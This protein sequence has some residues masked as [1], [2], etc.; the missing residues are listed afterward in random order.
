[1]RKSTISDLALLPDI[2]TRRTVGQV[3]DDAPFAVLPASE[4]DVAQRMRGSRRAAARR[5]AIPSASHRRSGRPGRAGSRGPM[6]PSICVSK[7]CGLL[8]LKTTRVRL[9]ACTTFRLRS[10]GSL[11]S[12]AVRP[13]PLPVSGKSSAMR[14]GLL[15]AKP[16]GGLA[17]GCLHRELDDR[18]SRGAL[19]H[20]DRVDAVGR[21]APARGR[22]PRRQ[23]GERSAQPCAPMQAPA[24][25]FNGWQ[26]AHLRRSCRWSASASWIVLDRSVQSPAPSCTSS[27]SLNFA[28]GDLDDNAEVLPHVVANLDLI[29]VLVGR[30]YQGIG[31]L[32]PLQGCRPSAGTPAETIPAVPC[33]DSDQARACCRP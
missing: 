17:S 29:D 14:G 22:C 31:V 13:N 23:G 6:L 4:I 25:S 26:G 20:G 15:I 12:C 16:A 19:R 18:A 3:D 2:D 1:M 5:T 24:F 30:A 7:V 9:P 10:A 32:A 33:A 11:T 27:L 28:V 21:S 8:R